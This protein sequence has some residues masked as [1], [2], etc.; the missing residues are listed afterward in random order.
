MKKMKMTRVMVVTAML[1]ALATVLQLM[2]ALIP[3]VA[4]FLD[5][6]FSDLPAIIGTLALGPLCGIAV[7]AIK[8]VLH[9]AVTTTG[10]VGELANFIVNGTFV[11]VLGLIY[12]IKKTKKTA[13]MGFVAA[14]II[15]TA[16]AMATNLFLMFP[17]YMPQ[18]SAEEMLSIILTAITPFNLAKGTVLSLITLAIY[19]KL[20]PIIKG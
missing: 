14:T 20:S 19:K 10:F 12:K 7:E 15:Y 16:A 4:G 13:V 3:R 1:S 17:L 5:V 18:A 8:N 9:C 11:L 2:G 6:E